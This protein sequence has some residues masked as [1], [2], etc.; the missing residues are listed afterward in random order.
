MIDEGSM[1]CEDGSI[2]IDELKR[3]IEKNRHAE[4]DSNKNINTLNSMSVNSFYHNASTSYLYGNSTSNANTNAYTN[5][6]NYTN[7]NSLTNSNLN[8]KT[9]TVNS[10]KPNPVTK[11]DIFNSSLNNSKNKGITSRKKKKIFKIVK[12]KSKRD[13]IEPS[14]IGKLNPSLT[15][16]TNF[17]PELKYNIDINSIQSIQSIP[18]PEDHKNIDNNNNNEYN[19]NNESLNDPKNSNKIKSLHTIS[20]CIQNAETFSETKNMNQNGKINIKLPLTVNECKNYL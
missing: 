8:N 5:Y 12:H 10:Y 9:F 3:N 16:R 14:F 15:L 17:N 2:D 13:T 4:N 18:T 20:S 11:F 19:N 1:K 6:T 7:S